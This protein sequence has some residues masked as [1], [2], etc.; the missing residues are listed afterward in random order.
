MFFKFFKNLQV[1]RVAPDVL[2]KIQK[3]GYKIT[4]TGTVACAS[5]GGYCGQCGD[6]HSA[7]SIDSFLKKQAARNSSNE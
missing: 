7:P 4:N 5:C 2:Q 6:D 1:P 3:M